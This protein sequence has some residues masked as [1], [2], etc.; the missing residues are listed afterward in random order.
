VYLDERPES[1]R[2]LEVV[3]ALG[4]AGAARAG[5]I[6]V[7]EPLPAWG[8]DA[9]DPTL[10]EL[11]EQV[12]SARAEHLQALAAEWAARGV[13]LTTR[14]TWGTSSVEVIREVL[15][16][17]H[18]LV[19][20]VARGR[21]QLGWPLFGSVAQHLVRKCPVPVWLV[22][23]ERPL[24]PRRV[25]AVVTPDAATPEPGALDLRV[26]ALARAVAARCGAELDVVRPWSVG[27]SRL[28]PAR[29]AALDA[30]ARLRAA[31]QE[32]FGKLLAA[33]EVDPRQA[34]FLEG[35]TAEAVARHASATG[36]DLVVIGT[37]PRGAVAGLLIREEA[38]DLLVRV[39]CSI[40]AVKPAD[41]ATPVRPADG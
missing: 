38:E 12:R 34:L 33:A 37:V 39:S 16:A 19:I 14:L 21:P 20:K 40:L 30:V 11:G 5:A 25:L 3:A 9:V 24:V 26:L 10:L 8:A 23:P 22:A 7:L 6:E 28:L 41:F 32:A 2:A 17:R 29:R 13:A 35:P 15:E 4:P 36:V 18:D 31:A 1:E 27:V